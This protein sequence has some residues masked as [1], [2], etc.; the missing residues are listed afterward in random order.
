MPKT[1]KCIKCGLRYRKHEWQVGLELTHCQKCLAISKG[2]QKS[3][4]LAEQYMNRKIKINWEII[5]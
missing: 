3:A 5:N 2:L 4:E 1:N